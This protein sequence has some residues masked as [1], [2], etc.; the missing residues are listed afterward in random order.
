[1]RHEG[2]KEDS[3]TEKT[4]SGRAAREM[5]TGLSNPHYRMWV[6]TTGSCFGTMAGVVSVS[7]K[8]RT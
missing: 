5:R 3:C 7:A 4:S 2:A 6:Q 8:G 1:V